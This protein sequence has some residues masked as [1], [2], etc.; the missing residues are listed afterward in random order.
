MAT[1]NVNFFRPALIQETTAVMGVSDNVNEVFT[2]SGTSQA[3]TATATV[4][5]NYVRVVASG[6]NV[7]LAF[8][9]SPTAVTGTGHLLID[10][11]PEIFFLE[12]GFK[13]ALI[14]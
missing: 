1:V 3:T 2:S 6:G 7:Y 13:V 14:N 4:D 9:A 5:R 11:I 8:A 10:G 12:N